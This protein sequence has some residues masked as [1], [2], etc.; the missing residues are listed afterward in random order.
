M[1]SFIKNE[2]GDSAWVKCPAIHQIFKT[3]GCGDNN[4]DTATQSANLCIISR[5]AK[6]GEMADI[7]IGR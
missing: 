6:N 3:A 2:M 1:V 7:Q 5:A 4:I